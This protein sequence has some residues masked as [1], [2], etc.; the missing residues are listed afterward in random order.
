M[1]EILF[2]ACSLLNGQTCE[3]KRLTFMEDPGSLS[4]FSCAFYGQIELAKWQMTNTNW[5]ASQ[6]YKCR[7]AGQYAKIDL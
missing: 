1:I 4:A 2:I 7:S 5:C 3:E 6:G